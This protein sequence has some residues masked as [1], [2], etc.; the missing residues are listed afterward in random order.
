[1]LLTMCMPANA[2]TL[3]NMSPAGSDVVCASAGRSRR[4][5]ALKTLMSTVGSAHQKHTQQWRA[6]DV[7][8]L[9]GISA[10]STCF[11]LMLC[12][13][14]LSPG[15]WGTAKALSFYSKG[16]AKARAGCATGAQ[17][18]CECGMARRSAI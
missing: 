3:T 14:Y 2:L 10:L 6:E 12:W 15:T 8:A 1:M 11:E 7:D 5:S 4:S 18:P 17:E 13:G 16:G 9:A